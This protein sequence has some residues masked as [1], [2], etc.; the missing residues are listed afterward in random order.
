MTIGSLV[1]TAG[2]ILL[3]FLGGWW[4]ARR[5]FTLSTNEEWVVG[6]GIGLVLETWFANLLPR[7]IPTPLSFWLS[8]VLVFVIGLLFWLPFNKDLRNIFR[9][10]LSIPLV[11]SFLLIVYSFTMIGRG[12]GLFDD[13]QNLPLA[14]R[15]AAGDIPPHYPLNPDIRFSYH[16]LLLL[17]SGQIS[18]LAQVGPWL[19]NDLARALVF[20]LGIIIVGM[21]AYRMTR[22]KLVGYFSAVVASFTMGT[23]WLLL[24]LPPTVTSAISANIHFIDSAV[25][26]APNLFE[27]L[28]K[29]WQVAGAGP[30]PFPFA[31]L[32][33]INFPTILDHNGIGFLHGMM[34]AILLLTFKR[35]KGWQSAAVTAVLI[36]SLALVEEISTVLIIGSLVLVILLFLALNRKTRL[37]KNMLTWLI[38]LGVSTVLIIFQGGVIS[39]V[40]YKFIHPAS[41]VPSYYV[42]YQFQFTFPPVLVS[43]GLGA[44]S[45]FN[46]SQLLVA[47][48]DFGPIFLI[49]P[50]AAIYG[51][52][53]FRAKRW[54][55]A[56]FILAS[57]LSL[58]VSLFV[59][60]GGTVGISTTTRFYES[61]LRM[62]KIY[63]VPLLFFWLQRK[64]LFTKTL[65]WSLA[66]ISILGGVVL[67]GVESIAVQRPVFADFIKQPDVTV[68]QQYWN[69]LEPGALVFDPEPNRAVTVFGRLTDSSLSWF[70][71]KPE[72]EALVANPDPYSARA[73]GYSYLYFD[74]AY[75]DSLSPAAQSALSSKCVILMT[76]V[77]TLH[78]DSRRLLDI[79]TCIP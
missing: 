30:F 43:E 32:S 13:F 64:R 58:G 16:Y 27:G 72:W 1:A 21:V 56:S 22:N 8:A 23:R 79:R 9:F 17:F 28:V 31:F 10:R 53:A 73:Q 65:S 19:S 3:W 52:R 12:L 36:A 59:V 2:W 29:P 40:V 44:L 48:L 50:L 69:K 38:V 24:F 5:A 66:G 7:I 62:L 26:T 34:L 37:S 14:S 15:L 74:Q 71:T 45:L 57:L 70:E 77:D 18:R 55:E 42:D 67:F 68:F 6:A 49:L 39:E 20:G 51:Y 41:T 33:G 4:I 63:A 46:P 54:F 75:W 11:I 76:E 47:L 61:P 60:T 78:G 25:A 35:W